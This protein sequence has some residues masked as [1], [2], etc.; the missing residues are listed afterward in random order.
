MRGRIPSILY[1]GT[2]DAYLDHILAEGLRTDRPSNWENAGKDHVYMTA[3][4]QTAAF[5][6]RRTSDRCG[7]SPIVLA[8]RK[9]WRLQADWD[10]ENQLTLNPNVP[11]RDS[12]LLAKGAGLF[13]SP[14]SVSRTAIL[15]VLEPQL[16]VP[17]FNWTCRERAGFIQR[18]LS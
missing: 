16:S 1:H 17:V 18:T 6:A 15:E 3:T 9:P 7:G 2:T 5:H 13:A 4:P 8:C 14:S 12:M 11:S 10:V